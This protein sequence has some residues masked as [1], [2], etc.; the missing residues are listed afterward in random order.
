MPTYYVEDY[1]GKREKD[2]VPAAPAEMPASPVEEVTA[3]VVEPETK[4][5]PAKKT[6]KAQT[7]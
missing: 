7:K 5:A 6:A 3:K 4:R 1:D 2:A